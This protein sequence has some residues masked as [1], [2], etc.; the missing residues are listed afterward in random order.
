MIYPDYVFLL[1]FTDAHSVAQDAFY[2]GFTDDGL[3]CLSPTGC[4]PERAERV[5][6]HR[7]GSARLKQTPN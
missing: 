7:D 2:R 5:Q 4:N 6:E 1:L 3:F